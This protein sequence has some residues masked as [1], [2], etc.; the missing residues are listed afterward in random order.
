MFVNSTPCSPPHITQKKKKNYSWSTARDDC[1]N[2]QQCSFSEY[3][4]LLCWQRNSLFQAHLANAI[5]FFSIKLS[6]P[7]CPYG[8][9]GRREKGQNE[10]A[11]N[12]A[13]LPVTGCSEGGLEAFQSLP[14][15][16]RPRSTHVPPRLR[17]SPGPLPR[18]AVA[19][20]VQ[21]GQAAT[22]H[23]P[24]VLWAPRC[25]PWRCQ[26]LGQWHLS[27]PQVFK[28]QARFWSRLWAMSDCIG[29]QC[30]LTSGQS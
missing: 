15:A 27:K 7:N 22:A 13:S 19:K 28:L 12:G 30:H 6:F 20:V 3:C 18:M 23:L 4:H 17:K 2:S 25:S 11:V 29:W 10:K 16:T 8:H 1:V 5:N 24:S 21:W 26:V 14:W 9:P